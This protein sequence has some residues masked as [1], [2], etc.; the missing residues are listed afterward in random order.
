MNG[1]LIIDKPSDWTSHDIVAKLRGVLRERRIGHGGTLDPMATGV[2]PVFIGRSTRAIE[3]LPTGKTYLAN[4]KL[5]I[6]TDTYDTTGNVVAT[7]GE[8]PDFRYVAEAA[9][10]FVGEREQVPPMVSAVKVN[11]QPLYKLARKGI[12]IER[13]SRTVKFGRIDVRQLENGEIELFIE[14]S[15]GTYIRSLCHDIGQV[16]GCGAAMSALRRLKSGA[17]DIS[18]AVTLESVTPDTPLLPL[19]ALFNEFPAY[20]ATVDEEKFIRNGAA[21]SV[22]LSNGRY[23]VYSESGGFLMLGEVSGMKMLTVK[24]FFEVKL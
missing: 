17:F 10:S 24:N 15:G 5:G 1:I 20:T 21:F 8:I 19:D 11:G 18:Q 2:L 3:L 9:A 22:E 4:M 16:L 6:V 23:R 12:E 7:S 14:C 13:R